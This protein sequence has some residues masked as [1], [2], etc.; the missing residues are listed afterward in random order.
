LQDLPGIRTSSEG[1][2]EERQVVIFPSD[3]KAK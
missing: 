3:A 1:A 2:G